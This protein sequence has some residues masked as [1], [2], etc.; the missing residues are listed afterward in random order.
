MACRIPPPHPA[1]QQATLAPLLAGL[2]QT[3]TSSTTPLILARPET[4]MGYADL[5]ATVTQLYDAEPLALDPREVFERTL[6]VDRVTRIARLAARAA[7][8]GV[9]AA[10][11]IYDLRLEAAASAA[12]SQNG[13]DDSNRAQTL[14]AGLAQLLPTGATLGLR[15]DLQRAQATR[16]NDP[17]LYRQ[18]VGVEARQPLLRGL[19]ATVTEAQIS[20]AELTARGARADAGSTL[21]DQLER[22]LTI[23]WELIGAIQNYHVGVVNYAA[24]H[25]LARVSRARFRL[26]L[27][28]LSDMLQVEAALDARVNQLLVSRQRVRDLEDQLK[29]IIFLHPPGAA[30]TPDWHV[31]VRPTRSIEWH[32]LRID[33]PALIRSALDV[34]RELAA[35]RAELDRA[36]LDR[37]VARNDLRP[38]L[39]LFG[40]ATANGVGD[41]GTS[42][43]DPVRQADF[44]SWNVGLSFSF[45]LQN[46]AARYG[47]AR[48]DREVAQAHDQLREL[49]DR[50]IAEVRAAAR[51]LRTARRQINAADARV[52]AEE[53][54]V[55]VA[56]RT[57]EVGLRDTFT[58]LQFQENLA[59]ARQAYVDAV[60]DYNQARIALARAAGV[61]A[62]GE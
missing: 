57:W 24:A 8:L 25:E 56:Q 59:E 32:D 9:G 45:P 46:R 13:Q 54:N 2:L 37:R 31:Q 17:P 1:A 34:R 23:Y 27:L 3:P 29:L 14:G 22:A 33:E 12:F 41:D 11:G 51:A 21:E 39:D 49:S 28:T 44:L 20:R 47:V 35:A 16:D 55:F 53:R 48:A 30:A 36:R 26:E 7:A 50:I 61:L 10:E 6:A 38:Q 5:P 58:L 43:F 52:R 62:P 18:S 4:A 60:V 15:Y 19:G 40:A 42:S